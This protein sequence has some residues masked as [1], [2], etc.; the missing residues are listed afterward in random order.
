MTKL[1]YIFYIFKKQT[2]TILLLFLL[3]SSLLF[4]LTFGLSLK[5]TFLNYIQ[6][7][8]GNIPDLVV[9]FRNDIDLKKALAL[10][11]KIKK[12]DE[13]IF[14]NIGTS[15][16]FKVTIKDYDDFVLFKD[17]NLSISGL[18]LPKKLD[19]S[20]DGKRYDLNL[21]DL[22]YDD[23]LSIKLDIKDIDIKNINTLTFLSKNKPIEYDFCK[24]ITLLDSTVTLS[25]L[26]CKSDVDRF[27]ENLHNKKRISLT[28]NNTPYE[29]KI[30]KVDKAGY[31]VVVDIDSKI[32]PNTLSFNDKSIKKNDIEDFEKVDNDLYIY[33]KENT[34]DELQ[35]KRFL[36]KI[37]KNFFN[38]DRVTL[39][40]KNY[41]FEDEKI[42]DREKELNYLN[43][44]TNIFDMI[45]NP[46]IAIS[47]TYLAA[48]LNNFDILD[49]FHLVYDMQDIPFHI[50]SQIYFNPEKIYDKNILFFNMELLDKYFGNNHK[51]NYINI[52]RDDFDEDLFS[53]IKTILQPYDATFITQKMIAPSLDVKKLTFNSS[54]LGFEAFVLI[55]F[56]ISLY[57]ILRQFYSNYYDELSLFKLYGSKLLYQTYINVFTFALACIAVLFFLKYKIESVNA[58]LLK[59]FF[60]YY[61][62]DIRYFLFS[63]AILFGI[64]ALIAIVEK[65]LQKRLNLIS[66][67]GA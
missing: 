41:S 33:L 54:I 11:K 51:I 47:S 32:E 59:Y 36:A 20:I 60:R 35:I 45:Q 15:K 57:V 18:Y 2:S 29:A 63:V 8:Y 12:I 39:K 30:K 46:H 31:I 6:T 61:E 7:S 40:V 27:L 26:P 37:A 28:I 25:A 55:V 62:F 1:K 67:E 23:G 53:Q 43:K 19:V 5:S 17:F 42:S 64:I 66:S 10:Q 52:Y 14:T 13:K 44:I 58:I 16:K 56:L 48:D 22:N 21:L 24:K 34:V 65:N 9:K 50:R 4:I 38:Y 49:N 3:F